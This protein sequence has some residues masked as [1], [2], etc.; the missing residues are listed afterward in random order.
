MLLGYSL[1]NFDGMVFRQLPF[2][3]E[4]G[5]GEIGGILF[6]VEVNKRLLYLAEYE[7]NLYGQFV[8]Y[9]GF[10]NLWEVPDLNVDGTVI[11]MPSWMRGQIGPKVRYEGLNNLVPYVSFKYGKLWGRFNMDQEIQDLSGT[12]NKKYK[13]L[14]DFT[15]SVGAEFELARDLTVLGEITLMPYNGGL[16]FSGMALL[17]YSFQTNGRRN[18]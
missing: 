17:R 13:A 12:E 2:S 10:N 1:S 7:I 6:G 14:G 8:Y 11:G 4:V 18:Q 16:D 3:V 15:L 9:Y 5:V